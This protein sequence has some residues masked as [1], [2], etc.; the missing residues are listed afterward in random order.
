MTP[1]PLSIPWPHPWTRL[2]L[3]AVLI[4]VGLTA[5]TG[6]G[7]ARGRVLT[8][9]TGR[10]VAAVEVRFRDGPTVL[11]DRRGEYRAE[12]LGQG[13]HDVA[14]VT[15][16]CEVALGRIL[17][18]ADGDWVTNLSLPDVM[19]E[20]HGRTLPGEGEGILLTYADL[21]AIPAASLADALRRE[22]PELRIGVPGQPGQTARVHGRNQATLTGSTTPLF[23]LDG[24]RMG[25]D[26]RILWDIT[27]GEV[28]AVEVLRGAAGGWRY[29]ADAAGGMIRIHTR[30]A[31]TEGAGGALP[32]RCPRTAWAGGGGTP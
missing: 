3:A 1:A 13:W 20:V 9:E 22:L 25:N 2:V 4:P 30:G 28:A 12:G 5:Q 23:I 19:A 7:G 16:A 32:G 17:V 18:P 24:I 14:L 8:E 26:P 15:A 27:P 29:G 10:P 11:T 6:A 31:R 21:D